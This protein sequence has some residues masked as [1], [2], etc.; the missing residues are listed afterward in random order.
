MLS[1]HLRQGHDAMLSGLVSKLTRCLVRSKVQ[2]L[3]VGQE[4]SGMTLFCLIFKSSTPLQRRSEQA[5]LARQVLGHT[6]V[7]E[8]VTMILCISAHICMCAQACVQQPV[9]LPNGYMMT[10]Y[11][12]MAQGSMAMYNR[13]NGAQGRFLPPTQSWHPVLRNS[14]G[15][16]SVLLTPVER[17]CH[18]STLTLSA[19]LVCDA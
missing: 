14:V 9:Y 5:C 2:P 11:P 13:E 1:R 6:H 18:T 3:E 17:S 12:Q 16:S 4:R 15:A 7:L 10:Y 8:C 19:R